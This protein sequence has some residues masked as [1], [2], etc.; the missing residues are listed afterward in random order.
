M[1]L[2]GYFVLQVLL[3]LRYSGRWRIAALAP[4]LVMIPAVV[5]AASALQAGSNLWPIVVIFT[6]PFAFLYLCG[7]AATRWVI[8]VAAA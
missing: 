3:A 5:H 2:P 4:L 7:L 1:T 8:A 6:A